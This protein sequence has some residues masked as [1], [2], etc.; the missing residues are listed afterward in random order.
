MNAEERELLL[1]WVEELSVGIEELD[2][3]HK[4]MINLINKLYHAVNAN[5]GMEEIGRLAADLLDYANYHFGAEEALFELKHYPDAAVHAEKHLE[6]RE[7]M[8]EFRDRIEAGDESAPSGLNEFL[9]VWW[10]RHIMECDKKYT[11]FLK[12]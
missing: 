9:F 7:N 8:G 1:R 10:T 3:H 5:A 4:E 12:G 2:D 6:Y 11:P